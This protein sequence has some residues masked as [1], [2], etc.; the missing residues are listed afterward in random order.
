LTAFR[1]V[2]GRS[3]PQRG[4]SVKE[5]ETVSDK[6]NTQILQVFFCQSLQDCIVDCVFAECC[7]ILLEA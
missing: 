4:E 6:I 2:L 3:S 5:L 1:S 7:L